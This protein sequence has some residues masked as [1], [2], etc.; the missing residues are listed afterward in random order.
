MLNNMNIS[1]A[2]LAVLLAIMLCGFVGFWLGKR[3]R[4]SD[5]EDAPFGIIQASAF[6]LVGLLL[7]FSFS[8]AVSRFDQRRDI[9][10]REANAIG[11]AALRVTL[12]NETDGRQMWTMLRSYARIRVDFASAGTKPGERVVPG[13][14]SDALQAQMWA[15]AMH[16]A[17]RD[18]R[19]TMVPLFIQSLNEAIDVSGEQAA[20][21]DATIPESVLLIVVGVMLLAAA[22][23]GVSFARGAL[24]EMGPFVLFGAMLALTFAVILDLDRPQ[25]GLIRVPLTPLQKVVQQLEGPYPGAAST[26]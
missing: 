9:T 4:P 23:L 22:L 13:E 1:I 11:R 21:L 3:S 25:R 16:A 17:A 10:V 5:K 2:A 26:R 12:L 7:G 15:T 19:S 18:P 14:R 6:G 8:L 24:F 20:A